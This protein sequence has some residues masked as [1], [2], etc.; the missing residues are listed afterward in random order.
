VIPRLFSVQPPC[1][2]HLIPGFCERPGAARILVRTEKGPAAAAA[3][4]LSRAV[5]AKAA[6]AAA[7]AAALLCFSRRRANHAAVPAL[8]PKHQQQQ[9]YTR[10]DRSWYVQCKHFV[11]PE[12]LLC[13][14]RTR[15]VKTNCPQETGERLRCAGINEFNHNAPLMVSASAAIERTNR[16]RSQPHSARLWHKALRCFPLALTNHSLLS[17]C[18][19]KSCIYGRR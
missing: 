6:S 17:A 3:A 15:A 11:R 5:A 9:R 14:A 2:I 4:V 13:A 8:P 10:R 12:Y 1:F 18:T 16:R 19:L 7:A